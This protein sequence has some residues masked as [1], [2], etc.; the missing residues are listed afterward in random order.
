MVKQFVNELF[1]HEF[2]GGS[3]DQRKFNEK[4]EDKV[5]DVSKP[6]LLYYDQEE[7][8]VIVV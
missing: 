8:E 4:T 2:A 1:D 7:I 6:L 3:Q 5:E